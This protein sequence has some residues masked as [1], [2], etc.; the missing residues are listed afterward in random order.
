MTCNSIS[1]QM[2]VDEVDFM[3]Q[4]LTT[5]LEHQKNVTTI[6]NS[7]LRTARLQRDS[8]KIRGAALNLKT[9][10]GRMDKIKTDIEFLNIFKKQLEMGTEDDQWLLESP[11]YLSTIQ[12]LRLKYASL[13][14][15]AARLS[16]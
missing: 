16:L 9:A 11:V 4:K 15:A 5:K 2:N 13:I 3:I 8:N 10:V 14:A 7:R 1:L 12:Q 6:L